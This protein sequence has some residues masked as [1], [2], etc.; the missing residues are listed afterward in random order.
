MLAGLAGLCHQL[1]K[2]MG[3]HLLHQ[4]ANAG[5]GGDAGA[6]GALCAEIEDATWADE[7]AARRAY[8]DAS[9]NGHRIEITTACGARVCLAVNYVAGVVLVESACLIKP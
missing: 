6:M 7:A 1:M 3:K 4:L 9:H 5:A 2:L 8:P